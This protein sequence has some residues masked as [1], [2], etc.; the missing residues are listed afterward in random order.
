M[1]P[2]YEVD[3]HSFPSTTIL[4]GEYDALR[5]DSEGYFHKLNTAGVK[6]EKIILPGQTHNTIMMRAV[7]SDST[8]PAEIIANIAKIRLADP[9]QDL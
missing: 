4:C 2:Y 5:N 8:D 9:K 6:V 7:L 3:F 1:S